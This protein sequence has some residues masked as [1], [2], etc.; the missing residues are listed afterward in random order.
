[1][2]EL[3]RRLRVMS[4]ISRKINGRWYH[5]AKGGE[6]FQK[7]VA[8]GPQECRQATEE[9]S[10]SVNGLDSCVEIG[11]FPGEGEVLLEILRVHGRWRTG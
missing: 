9:E 7:G 6:G 1:M 4:S 8:N 11:T 2:K 5:K 10:I 3:Q